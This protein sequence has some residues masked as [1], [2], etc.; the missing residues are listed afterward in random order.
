MLWNTEFDTPLS[1]DGSRIVKELNER[2]TV[3]TE[4]DLQVIHGLG[5]DAQAVMSY[6]DER[7]NAVV[8]QVIPLSGDSA[9]MPLTLL[10]VRLLIL[11][12]GLYSMT[13]GL[14]LGGR[15]KLRAIEGLKALKRAPS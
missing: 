6:V 13:L 8:D 14:Q 3:L 2:G 1:D 10:D 15:N 11:V 7:I 12:T 5:D 4:E 9:M